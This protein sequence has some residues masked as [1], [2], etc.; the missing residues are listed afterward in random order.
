MSDKRVTVRYPRHF[1]TWAFLALFLI[2]GYILGELYTWR[3]D[4]GG[5]M[6]FYVSVLYV[7]RNTDTI[8]SL[9]ARAL[10]DQ[11]SQLEEGGENPSFLIE[12]KAGSYSPFVDLDHHFDVEIVS[13]EEQIVT[14]YY[15]L[16]LLNHAEIRYRAREKTIELIYAKYGLAGGAGYFLTFVV[17]GIAVAVLRIAIALL[18]GTINLVVRILDS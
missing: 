8:R 7:N 14:H 16:A 17:A 11:I 12:D 15:E 10:E 1:W 3:P 5:K 4:E 2:P 18:I 6:P 13:D 9:S